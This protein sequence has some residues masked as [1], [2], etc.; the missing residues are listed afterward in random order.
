MHPFVARENAHYA[1]L[2]IM[3]NKNH[4]SFEVCYG[5]PA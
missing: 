1:T 2:L 5:C 3:S 4:T